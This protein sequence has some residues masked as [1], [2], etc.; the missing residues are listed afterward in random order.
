MRR[1]HLA[2]VSVMTAVV[3]FATACGGSGGNSQSSV[4]ARPSSLAIGTV[5]SGYPTLASPSPLTIRK[6]VD[7]SAFVSCTRAHGLPRDPKQAAQ[8]LTRWRKAV[9]ACARQIPPGDVM[10]VPVVEG[11]PFQACLNTHGLKLPSP[12]RLLRLDPNDPATDKA[13]RSC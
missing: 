12:G 11:D 7:S 5:A 4:S 13:I 9:E 8:D 2:D 3:V 1:N 6:P 10:H